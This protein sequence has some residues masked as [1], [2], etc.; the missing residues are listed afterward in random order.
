[1][2]Y[3]RETIVTTVDNA[4]RALTDHLDGERYYRSRRAGENLERFHRYAAIADVL[5]AALDE[6]RAAV[7]A[8]DMGRG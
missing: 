7:D 3:I 1:M 8:L 2:P 4:V 6:T 5:L